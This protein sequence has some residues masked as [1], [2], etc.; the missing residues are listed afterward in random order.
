MAEYR[1]N[2]KN[3]RKSMHGYIIETYKED[4]KLLAQD[5]ENLA[6]IHFSSGSIGITND[7]D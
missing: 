4:H 6:Q 1:P 2:K 7:T 5:S 3:L